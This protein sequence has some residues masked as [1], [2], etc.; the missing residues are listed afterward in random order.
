MYTCDYNNDNNLF[1]FFT[2]FSF[3][4]STSGPPVKNV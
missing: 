3:D 2:I 1:D 4:D